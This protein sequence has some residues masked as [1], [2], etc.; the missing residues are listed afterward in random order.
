MQP[1][2]KPHPLTDLRVI[3]AIAVAAGI[4]LAVPRIV[5][6]ASTGHPEIAAAH[7]AS[8]IISGLFCMAIVYLAR[9]FLWR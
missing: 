8:G 6:Y 2:Q 5:H 1:K 9:R 3:G 4:A 7:L